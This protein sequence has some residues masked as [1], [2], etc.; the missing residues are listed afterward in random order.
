M[1]SQMSKLT[2]VLITA[3]LVCVPLEAGTRTVDDD[4]GADFTSIQPAI[5]A[6]SAGDIV[7]VFP[8]TYNGP[9][10]MKDEVNLFG[11]GPHVTTIDGQGT[12]IHVVDY[13]GTE[14]AVISGFRITG[15][16]ISS[17]GGTWHYAG[18][19][20]RQGPLTIRNNIIE[21]NQAAIAVQAAANP[22]I[23]NNTIVGNSTGVIFAARIAPSSSLID[24]AIISDDG[25]ASKVYQALLA[26]AGMSS[27]VIPMSQVTQTSFLGYRSIIVTTETGNMGNWGTT[28]AVAAVANSRRPVLGF[29]RGGS[30]LFQQMGL[31]IRWLYG[32][33]ATSHSTFV[34]APDD[35]VFNTPHNITIPT[36]RVLRLYN[37]TAATI[38][39][40][41]PRLVQWAVR[42]GA[43]INPQAD[44]YPLVREGIHTLWGFS[45]TPG[46]MTT[47]GRQLFIN[48]IRN[49]ITT[50]YANLP[51]P[52]LVAT[53]AVRQTN[54]YI[55]YNLSIKNWYMYPDELFDASPDL[56]PC[57]QNT[58]ASRTWLNIYDEKQTYLYGFCGF[59]EAANLQNFHFSLPGDE[60][61]LRVFVTLEDRRC[62]AI[63]T[64]NLVLPTF[65]PY[66]NHTILNNIIVENL[67]GIF[68]YRY[69]A[70]GHIAYN[71]VW[72][73][74]KN[75][76]DN[77]DGSSFSPL[78][79]TGQISA[80]PLFVDTVDYFLG[81][82]SP[83]RDTGHPGAQ[84]IDPDAT[85]N[86]MGAYGGPQASGRGTHPGSGFIF[87]S[88][89]NI[90]TSEIEQNLAHPSH[91][92]ADVDAAT[93]ADLHIPAYTDAPFGAT[94]RIHGLFGET[95][96]ANGVRY[97]QILLAPW[98]A[99]DDPPEPE[100]YEPLATGLSKVKYI[101]QPDATVLTQIITL[102]PQTI[103]GISNLYELTYQGWWSQ[104]D[105]RMIWNTRNN[106]N[107]KYTLTYKAYRY[108]PFFPTLLV[109]YFPTANDL[110]HIDLLVNNSSVEAVIHNVKYDT[111]S[112]HWSPATD[113]EIPE[114]GIINLQNDAENLRFN[115]TARHPDGYLR[116]WVLDALW[117]K[118]NYAGVIASDNY[119]G[120]VPPD[121]WPGVSGAEFNSS[122]GS[123]IPWQPCSYQF[124]LRAYTRS[125]N[126][127]GYL[128]SNQP[129][130]Y[131][132][133]FSDH[134]FID[135]GG[136]CA[137][138]GGADIN[139]DGTVDLEDVAIVGLHYLSLIP[140]GPD[141]P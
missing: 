97:Y 57:G 11:Y 82:G 32:W 106:P 55:R 137:W 100:D 31:S 129:I 117:G 86:D 83:C 134:Y 15:S 52:E 125:T 26:G 140:C 45:G 109:E 13:A 70:D 114:C 116:R 71:D 30:S 122:A 77:R 130:A 9:I 44:H 115:I 8:G 27:D 46:D 3:L 16:T 14:G 22:S 72:N 139:R 107:G 62:G 64:S 2:L 135:L 17:A 47:A 74:S 40:D 25:A 63:Y 108:H 29:G 112:P 96:I 93:A 38:E 104:I 102:G 4:G 61:P 128:T 88:I 84:Y 33:V 48:I 43:G 73:N 132:E 133:T 118:N 41:G 75:Y 49:M 6:S 42:L 113:G 10:T 35:N 119:P 80:N 69:L 12:A 90:P 37:N 101:P 60:T 51:E 91:G 65:S 110:D 111:T 21:D 138:C 7:Y 28:A 54:G 98:D 79:G 126:G 23:I 127:Y 34:V 36:N 19:H 50:C 53:G 56:D 78:P 141:C 24:V 20:V 66:Y 18:I 124:R 123:L 92:L 81:D 120:T 105:L 5:D 87:T 103:S 89:G 99:P 76:H 94:I 39:I 58:N 121:N 85:R 136:S 95:D 131:S 67:T 1:I 59:N 68:Y